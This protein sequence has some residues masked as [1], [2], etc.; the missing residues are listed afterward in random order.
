MIYMSIPKKASYNKKG[1]IAYYRD[2]ARI[3]LNSELFI[4]SAPLIFVQLT[5]IN[6]QARV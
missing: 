3:I 1:I 4:Y 6:I 2:D 5:H